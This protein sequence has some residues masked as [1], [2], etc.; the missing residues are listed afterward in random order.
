MLRSERRRTSPVCTGIERRCAA[1]KQRRARSPAIPL[2][3]RQLRV[4]GRTGHVHEVVEIGGRCLAKVGFDDRKIVYYFL[5]DLE[6]DEARAAAPFTMPKAQRLENHRSV[7]A[8]GEGHR[9]NRGKSGGPGRTRAR[10]AYADVA[11]R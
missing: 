4:C 1:S 9:G 8:R 11:Q 10:G 7:S 2:H 6:L 5:D 3:G